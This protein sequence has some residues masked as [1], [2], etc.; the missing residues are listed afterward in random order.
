MELNENE[1]KMSLTTTGSI[2]QNNENE[3]YEEKQGKL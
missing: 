1:D 3:E 2:Y